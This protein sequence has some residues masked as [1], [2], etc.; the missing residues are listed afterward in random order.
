[1]LLISGNMKYVIFVSEHPKQQ[2]LMLTYTDAVSRTS[3]NSS[4][5]VREWHP[6]LLSMP[7][8]RRPSGTVTTLRLSMP[9]LSPAF[10]FSPSANAFL[11]NIQTSTSNLDAQRLMLSWI[12]AVRD[13]H[14][15]KIVC[16]HSLA[17]PAFRFGDKGSDSMRRTFEAG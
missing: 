10:S 4:D 6:A 17:S 15:F 14:D 7:I 12:D 5:A 16:N 3:E 1:M 8:S 11:E 2:R 9:G 13:W